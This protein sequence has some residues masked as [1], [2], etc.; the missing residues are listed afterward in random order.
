[1]VYPN[2]D[3]TYYDN[4]GN[5]YE[6]TQFAMKDLTKAYALL[7]M[8]ENEAMAESLVE[9]FGLSE[10]RSLQVAKL[11]NGYKKL[12][13]TRSLE[14]K[15]LKALGEELLGFDLNLMTQASFADESALLEIAA[16]KNNISPEHTQEILED[17]LA[18]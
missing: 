17:L 9:Q 2:G 7:E 18:E 10:E 16:K 5:I 1:N 8:Q 11:L 4:D 13:Q 6:T 12:S 14:T 15:D 3:G